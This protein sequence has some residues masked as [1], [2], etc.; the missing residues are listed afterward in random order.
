MSIEDRIRKRKGYTFFR[1]LFQRLKEIGVEPR[2]SL[3]VLGLFHEVID[4]LKEYRYAWRAMKN[5][6]TLELF[7]RDYN[8]SQLLPT[9]LVPP[10]VA[11]SGRCS[12]SYCEHKLPHREKD[13]C[14]KDR[15]DWASWAAGEEVIVRCSQDTSPKADC[16]YDRNNVPSQ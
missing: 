16:K 9:V 4:N 10:L 8:N 14:R 7:T 3:E 13:A 1:N 6:E 5:T 15:C 12:N 2:T 11:C